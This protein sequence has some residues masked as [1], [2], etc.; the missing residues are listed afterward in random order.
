MIEMSSEEML[1]PILHDEFYEC[2][3]SIGNSTHGLLLAEEGELTVTINGANEDIELMAEIEFED[4]EEE[5]E[6]CTRVRVENGVYYIDTLYPDSDYYHLR[7]FVRHL[8]DDHDHFEEACL[9]RVKAA[10]GVG[11]FKRWPQ[12][13]ANFEEDKLRLVSHKEGIIQHKKAKPLP[14]VL[15]G[16]READIIVKVHPVNNNDFDNPDMG[17][18]EPQAVWYRENKADDTFDIKCIFPDAGQWIVDIYSAGEGGSDF[19][20]SLRYK[21]IANKGMGDEN[22]YPKKYAD[23]AETDKLISPMTGTLWV[24]KTYI[25]EIATYGQRIMLYSPDVR[26]ESAQIINTFK[27]GSTAA[28]G[29]PTWSAK[30]KISQAYAGCKLL[31]LGQPLGHTDDESFDYLLEYEVAA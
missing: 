29:M 28:T 21:V 4:S 9:Y 6:N 10:Q 18:N 15:A 26:D 16:A 12:M 24:G 23:Y 7:L 31:L 2:G 5:V 13:W 19:A 1:G 17:P 3:L 22:L 11:D 14:I 30:V 20:Q 25:F 27:Q 8:D